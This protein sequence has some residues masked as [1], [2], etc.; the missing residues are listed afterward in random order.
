MLTFPSLNLFSM[1]SEEH[2]KPD[3]FNAGKALHAQ[4]LKLIPV[5]TRLNMV[6]KQL[7]EQIMVDVFRGEKTHANML[8]NELVVIRRVSKLVS[9]LKVIFET[10]IVRMATLNDYNDFHSSIS[11]AV[12]SL[13]AIKSDLKEVTPA[14]KQVF[15]DLSESVSDISTCEI[16]PSPK[17]ANVTDDALGILE[18]ASTIVEEGLKRKF[19]TLPE[20]KPEK[21]VLVNA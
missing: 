15:A 20:I 18:E 8:A 16:K 12:G 6:E 17:A 11:S 9:D 5:E 21:R 19:S 10:L 7:Q 1:H 14:A 3:M 2:S 4:F 13:K